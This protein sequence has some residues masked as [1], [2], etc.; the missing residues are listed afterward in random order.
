MDYNM[1]G[2]TDIKPQLNVIGQY[3]LVASKIYTELDQRAINS[4]VFGGKSDVV[5][6]LI[7]DM[8][9]LLVLLLI[10]DDEMRNHLEQGNL[11]PWYDKE[12]YIEKYDLDCI[13]TYFMCKGIDIQPMLAIIGLNSKEYPKGIGF[14]YIEGNPDDENAETFTVS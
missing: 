10:I 12:Y 2:R 7:N 8:H 5:Y 13:R 6:S 11:A 3:Q 14:M 4:I 1:I 9:F